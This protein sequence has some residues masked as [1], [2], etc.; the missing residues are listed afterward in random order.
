MHSTNCVCADR[1]LEVTRERDEAVA[2][3]RRMADK[4]RAALALVKGD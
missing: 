3:L 1:L 2:L 4:A